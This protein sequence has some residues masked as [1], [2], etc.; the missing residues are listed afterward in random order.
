[1]TQDQIKWFQQELSKMLAEVE[2]AIAFAAASEAEVIQ[3]TGGD[4]GDMAER[5]LSAVQAGMLQD[6]LHRQRREIVMALARIENGEYGYCEDTGD[7][8]EIA[9]LRAN[10]VARYS[11]KAQQLRERADKLRAS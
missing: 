10:P 1:V 7:E 9:R 3:E 8:I 6:R 4:E 11:L 5:R 2:Q